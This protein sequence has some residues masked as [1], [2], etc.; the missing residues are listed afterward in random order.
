MARQ[1]ALGEAGATL[2]AA[3]RREEIHAAALAAARS[4][5]DEPAEVVLLSPQEGPLADPSALVLEL[6]A[7]GD[8]CTL[9]V[10]AGESPPARSVRGAL[11]ALAAQVSL[12]LHSAALTEKVVRRAGEARLSSLVQHSN[13][14][15]TVLDR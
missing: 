8:V 14:L 2:V 5:L 1:R 3:T 11:E 15:I 4:L 10:I 6:A 7:Q 13:D 12:A 9:L